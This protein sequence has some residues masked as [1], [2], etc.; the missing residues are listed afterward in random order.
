MG[1]SVGAILA[2]SMVLGL[3]PGGQ[4]RVYAVTRDQQDIVDR[5]DYLYDQVWVARETV[6]GWRGEH[7][8]EEGGTYHLPYAQPVEEG[9]YI[10]FGV[11]VE[12]FLRSAEEEGSVFYEERS[13]YGDGDSTYYGL[14]CSAFVSWCWG[15]DRH[16]TWS[17][18]IV[19]TV[20]GMATE[21]NVRGKLRLGDALNSRAAGHVV[22]VTGI[23]YDGEGIMESVEITEQTPPQLTRSRYTPEELAEK[24]GGRYQICR[25]EGDV[26]SVPEGS[27][28]SRCT[29]Y[30]AHGVVETVRGTQIL[31]QPKAGVEA[32]ISVVAGTRIT[33]TGLYEDPGGRSWYRT[34][35]GYLPAEDTVYLE[36]LTDS[37]TLTGAVAPQTHVAGEPFDVMGLVRGGHHRLVRVA[38]VVRRGA[39]GMVITGASDAVGGNSYEL[40]NSPVDEGTAFGTVPT[41]ENTFEV[42]AEYESFRAEGG[43]IR[44]VCGVV[45]LL[46]QPFLCVE[47]GVTAC[48][49]QY[50]GRITVVPTQDREGELTY[51]CACGDSFREVLPAVGGPP[52]RHHL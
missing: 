2:V 42:Y 49:H 39:G 37:V 22:L 27:M 46:S 43:Q 12:D 10:G 18:P 6:E 29:V 51:T 48:E 14:D 20:L 41:G 31:S 33:V 38:A 13:C 7:I 15:I 36:T 23:A 45:C 17:I 4:A 1:R 32:V 11:S 25:Y 34:G 3:L 44:R 47:D 9:R 52:G 35:D 16:T 24:Y 40:M 26:P 19:T 21:E 8:F 30:P 5:A 28:L 50:T